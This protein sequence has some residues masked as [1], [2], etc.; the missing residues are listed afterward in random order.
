MS[1]MKNMSA[2]DMK[3][4]QE[5]MNGMSADDMMKA[6]KEAGNMS[7]RMKQQHDY[8]Y[9]VSFR[10]HTSEGERGEVLWSGRLWILQFGGLAV[11]ELRR[12]EVNG[13]DV[14]SPDYHYGYLP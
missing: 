8:V 12:M 4:A 13:W 7:T 10:Q 14:G 2:D 9:N 1:Q 11:I 6:S 3:A 5:K